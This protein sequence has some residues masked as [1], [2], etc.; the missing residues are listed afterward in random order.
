MC[1][2]PEDN[3]CN[4]CLPTTSCLEPCPVVC[5][6]AVYTNDNCPNATT[7]N[8]VAF[9]GDPDTVIGIT[10][11]S[12]LT[13]VLNTIIGYIRNFRNK[14]IN[15]DGS[16][17]ITSIDPDKI[18]V[19]VR[20][21]KT[22][23]GNTLVLN[24]AGL[25]VA[26]TTSGLS[27]ISTL[28]SHS[29]NL[30]GNGTT[31]APLS[32]DV[33]ISPN[34]GN[35][36]SILPSGLYSQ[37]IDITSSKCITFTSAVVNDIKVYTPVIDWTCVS[38]Q[39]CPLCG[40]TI[41]PCDH[42]SFVDVS[43]PPAII[44]QPYNFDG[45][46]LFGTQPFSV[47]PG[48]EIHPSWLHISIVGGNKVNFYGTPTSPTDV[49]GNF[50]VNLI[51]EN[52]C[53]T[54]SYSHT[55][56]LSDTTPVCVNPSFQDT[57]A[58]TSA[59]VGVLYSRTLILNGTAPFTILDDSTLKLPT[60]LKPPV[61]SG[62]ILTLSGTPQV[63]DTTSNFQVAITI[64][65]ACNSI[66]YNSGLVVCNPVNFSTSII[67][68]D[69]V[70]GSVY[71]TSF[72][73]TGSVPI[74]LSNTSVYPSWMTVTSVGNIVNITNNTIVPLG[75]YNISLV[76]ANACNTKTLVRTIAG[77]NPPPPP[78]CIDVTFKNGNPPVS[79]PAATVGVDYTYVVDLNGTAPFVVTSSAAPSW[80]N[81][82]FIGNAL[83][84]HSLPGNPPNTSST[85]NVQFTITNCIAGSI[86]YTGNVVTNTPIDCH[87]YTMTA[88]GGSGTY[89]YT[90][91]GQ[92][93]ALTVSLTSGSS[94]SICAVTG[95]VTTTGQVSSTIGGVCSPAIAP[96]NFRYGFT[97]LNTTVG[98]AT[99]TDFIASVD[100]VYNNITTQIGTFTPGSNITVANGFGNNVDKVMFIQ[101]IASEP[102]F[103][104]YSVINDAI[105]QGLAVD[106][107]F[108]GNHLFFKTMRNGESLYI[109]RSQ[110][111]FPTGVIFSR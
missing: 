7:T 77:I 73:T 85:G 98:S 21:D 29:L 25:Y 35:E 5:E 11:N 96:I 48:S 63:G 3:P 104:K 108:I 105:Q 75:S 62:N 72:A 20:I 71:N 83:L 86:S 12:T 55:I 53:S 56:A 64:L 40:P 95:S 107:T 32:G 45:L 38:Q 102:A 69:A 106:Q 26:S 82:T 16:I 79:L 39:I 52:P 42:I 30:L 89:T 87:N 78:P 70:A 97:E 24:P 15:L 94:D 59:T 50:P 10:T 101:L 93:T 100:A 22:T 68:P 17:K 51:F 2:C 109:T 33:I 13:T 57:T 110:T 47:I 18:D 44:G 91:C 19:S 103:T 36:L 80:M 41:V 27:S 8:C 90:P 66:T 99:E 37:K 49:V 1:N 92:T 81:F 54:A 14:I 60:W 9:I 58:L 6:T 76:L 88:F 65:N 34:A 74:T 28:D 46:T 4:N 61:L 111:I 43:L 31:T 67:L 23:A 84:I